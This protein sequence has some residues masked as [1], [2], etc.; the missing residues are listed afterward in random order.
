MLRIP[1]A[2]GG[3]L[4]ISNP[5]LEG[6]VLVAHAEKLAEAEAVQK[7]LA[8]VYRIDGE[9]DDTLP[10]G[11]LLTRR[12]QISERTARQLLT[13]GKLGYVCAG[14]KA[15]RVSERHVRAF[16]DGLAA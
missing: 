7:A 6:Q 3:A 12:L 4:E 2:G 1:L 8:V 5:E 11:G 13:D 14:K 16:E 9:P 10:Y 15:Y